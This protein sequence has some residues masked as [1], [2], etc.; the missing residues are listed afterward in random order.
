MGPPKSPTGHPENQEGGRRK[1]LARRPRPRRCLLKGC[2]QPFR[3]RRARQRYC[4]EQCREAARAWS[5]WKAQQR[6]RATRAANGNATT[7]ASA[8]GSASGTE[9]HQQAKPFRTPRGSS[10]RSFF[11]ACCDRPGCYAGFVRQRRSPSQHFC[12]HECR[13]AMERVWE[14]ERHWTRAG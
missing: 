11:D 7:K 6:Y 1:R 4:S 12:S 8:T 14:R 3:P 9:N 5:G 13:R 10:L 2:E